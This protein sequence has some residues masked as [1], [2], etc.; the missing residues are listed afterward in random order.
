M[1]LPHALLTALVERSGSGS[2]LAARFDRSI[3]YFW[4]ATHQQIYR[5]LARLEG[6]G[7]IESLPEEPTRGRRRAYRILPAGRDE[8]KRWITQQE[9]PAPLRDEFMVR[10][11]AEAAVGPTGLDDEI[12]RRIALHEEQLAVYRDI[13][14]RD[15]P[16]EPQDREAALQRL[17]LQA[18]IRYE[19]YWL[20]ILKGALAALRMP[21]RRAE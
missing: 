14:K 18:G 10:L 21:A 7:L 17:V 16:D 8:L 2:E 6:G 9:A 11:R 15:F 19:S 13:E 4:H 12:R 5:E 1:S 20:E 3:G